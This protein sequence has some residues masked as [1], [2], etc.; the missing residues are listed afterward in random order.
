MDFKNK[1]P[2]HWIS[3]ISVMPYF[4]DRNPTKWKKKDEKGEKHLLLTW[5]LGGIVSGTEESSIFKWAGGSIRARPPLWQ[6]SPLD[7]QLFQW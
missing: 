1:K 7:P 6:F 2:I 4:I 3:Y 5:A